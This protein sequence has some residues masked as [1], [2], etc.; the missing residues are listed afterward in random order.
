MSNMIIGNAKKNMLSSN[1][2]DN[3]YYLE[4]YKVDLNNDNDSH[5]III[6]Q[7]ENP[8]CVLDVGCGVGYI[9]RT[10]KELYKV[11]VDGVEIDEKA[12]KIAQKV[13]DNVYDFSIE[14]I[15]SSAYQKFIKNDVKYDYIIF[16]DI[17]EHLVNPGL[18][19]YNLSQK[20]EKNGKIIISIPNIAH[21]NIITNLIKGNF[22][23]N[24]TG[25]LD[26]THLRFFTKNSFYDFVSNINKTYNTKLYVK[27]IGQTFAADEKRD[28]LLYNFMK[29][30]LYVFQNIFEL[31]FVECKNVHKSENNFDDV[32]NYYIES[33]NIRKD[34]ENI[35]NENKK[36]KEDL[37]LLE[38]R[39]KECS[40]TLNDI[41]NSKGYKALLKYYRFKDKIKPKK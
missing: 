4:E 40:S 33:L 24:K 6:K 29:D 1:E 41:I 14:D 13:Y 5:S 27:L 11:Q 15:E 17:I 25:I 16:A 38:D 39:Y 21:G 19:I 23:Y 34:Y 18:V 31:S 37:K 8:K 28:E 32:Y 30:D 22:N 20:L 26:T 12:K 7:V 10:L 3:K 35:K 9:G 36:L 2:L